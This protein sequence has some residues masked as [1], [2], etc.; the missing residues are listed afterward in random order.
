MNNLL[1][2]LADCEH[3]RW[4]SWHQYVVSKSQLN[5]D[6][7]ITIPKWAVDR[8]NTQSITKYSDLSEKEK[9]SDRKEVRNIFKIF[10][11]FLMSNEFA[12]GDFIDFITQELEL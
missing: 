6:G 12:D 2:V 11:E 3:E 1:E 4:S 7:S 10:I 8:W 5:D 9:E